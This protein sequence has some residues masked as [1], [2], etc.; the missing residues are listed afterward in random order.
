M[1]NDDQSSTKGGWTIGLNSVV[2]MRIIRPLTPV[3]S[4]RPTVHIPKNRQKAFHVWANI[5]AD[6]SK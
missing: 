2:I 4:S 5:L 3:Q 1:L 6:L